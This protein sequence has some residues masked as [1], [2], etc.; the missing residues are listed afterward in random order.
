MF[1]RVNYETEY[2]RLKYRTMTIRLSK[3]KDKD[4]IEMLDQLGQ[5]KNSYVK[6]V[7]RRS[8]S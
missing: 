5:S 4:L 8:M 7:L 1:D 6:E 3:E 2:R